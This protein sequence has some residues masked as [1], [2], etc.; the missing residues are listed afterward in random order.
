MLAGYDDCN[1]IEAPVGQPRWAFL[2]SGSYSPDYAD[3]EA[4]EA[5]SSRATVFHR[6]GLCRCHLDRWGS[7]R[8]CRT[9]EAEPAPGGIT[10]IGEPFW[11]QV[12]G[13]YLERAARRGTGFRHPAEP[14]RRRRS[15]P[16]EAPAIGHGHRRQTVGQQRRGTG[17]DRDGVVLQGGAV[18]ES[19]GMLGVVFL[20]EVFLEDWMLEGCQAG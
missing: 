3:L 20:T 7:C 17:R 6:G 11:R 15:R 18:R 4:M 9:P 1:P 2:F 8:Y 12:A 10:L 13:M 5:V 19:G 14:L 16:P